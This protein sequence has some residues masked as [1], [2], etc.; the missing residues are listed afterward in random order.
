MRDSA[1]QQREK[2]RKG[3]VLGANDM[4]LKKNKEKQALAEAEEG[5]HSEVGRDGGPKQ[6]VVS[7][8]AGSEKE[9]AMFEKIK[10]VTPRAV[11]VQLLKTLN[12]YA[13]DIINRCLSLPYVAC[14]FLGSS[15][16]WLAGLFFPLVLLSFFLGLSLANMIFF[17][18]LSL[19]I[20]QERDGDHVGRHLRRQVRRSL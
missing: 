11:W 8:P 16:C 6:L 9:I 2:G 19:P 3:S 4:R 18:V 14:P 15:V 17:L 10:Q 12:L 5:R 20:E 1:A 13:H 7:Y